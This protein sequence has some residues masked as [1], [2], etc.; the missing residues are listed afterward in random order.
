[1]FY[2][3]LADLD[4]VDNDIVDPRLEV[5]VI[6]NAKTCD[7]QSL[8]RLGPS[9]RNALVRVESFYGNG[10]GTIN[11]KINY[12]TIKGTNVQT[13]QAVSRTYNAKK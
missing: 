7:V 11:P 13:G 10:T 8:M 4:K 6:A 3:T 9:D 12:V 1:M 2:V 5:S